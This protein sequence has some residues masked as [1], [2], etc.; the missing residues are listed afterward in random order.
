MKEIPNYLDDPQ[1]ILFWEFDE[2]ILLAIM[3][4][5]GIMVNLLGTLVL[6]GFIGIKYYRKL[7]DRQAAGFLYM[8]C[9]GIPASA[10][11]KWRQ[12]HGPSLSSGAFFKGA[13]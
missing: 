13:T 8:W 10:R 9:T 1:Q 4:G 3:F 2:F 5:I 12:R 7:K 6:I 11:M